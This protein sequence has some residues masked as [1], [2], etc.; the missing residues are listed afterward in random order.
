MSNFA[1]TQTVLSTNAWAL[2][3]NPDIY[4]P[5]C[6]E[7]RPERWQDETSKEQHKLMEDCYGSFGYGSRTCLGKNMGLMEMCRV[8]Q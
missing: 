6:N 8:S 5:G 3:R 2:H 1:S 4:G 7:F